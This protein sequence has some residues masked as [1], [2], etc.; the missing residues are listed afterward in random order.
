MP[1]AGCG[2]WVDGCRLSVAGCQLQ[3]AGASPLVVIPFF[4]CHSERSEEPPHLARS[5]TKLQGTTLPI[6]RQPPTN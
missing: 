3:V 4:D 6:I 1:V 5:A 2:L